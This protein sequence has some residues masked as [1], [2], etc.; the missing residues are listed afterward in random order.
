[1]DE[2][3]PHNL[4][5]T[6][7]TRAQ[8]AKIQANISKQQDM[9]RAYEARE[10]SRTINDIIEM[11]QCTEE[12]AVTALKKSKGS[13]DKAISK[14]INL[15]RKQQVAARRMEMGTSRTQRAVSEPVSLPEDAIVTVS[16]SRRSSTSSGASLGVVSQRRSGRAKEIAA[17]P[18]SSK[19]RVI[20]PKIT[21]VKKMKEVLKKATQK[22]QVSR[23]GRVTHKATK[24]CQLISIGA[25]DTRLKFSNSG[26]IFPVGFKSYITYISSED[27]ST[28]CRHT[29]EIVAPQNVGKKGSRE[30][31]N[32]RPIFRITAEDREDEPL[33]GNSATAPW[34]KILERINMGRKKRKMPE[35]HTAIAG[36]EYFGLNSPDVVQ[37]IEALPNAEKCTKYWAGKQ[38]L[39]AQRGLAEKGENYGRK[40]REKRAM[41]STPKPAKR[42]K[43]GTGSSNSRRTPSNQS[44]RR[45]SSRP[46][47]NGTRAASGRSRRSIQFVEDVLYTSEHEQYQ[48]YWSTVGRSERLRNRRKNAGESVDDLDLS[49]KTNN[50]LHG[51]IDKITLDPIENPH[52][53]PAGHVLGLQTWLMCIKRNKMCPFTKKIL[54]KSDLIKLTMDNF[55]TYKSKIVGMEL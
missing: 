28:H 38:V 2:G 9:L 29:C 23:F 37:A 36:P 19:A 20:I 39:L 30:W 16:S 27:P 40:A 31:N 1:M 14:L 13:F 50:P 52:M 11:M 25:I 47:R 10:K 54:K 17:K 35:K 49:D 6:K 55:R 48:G 41:T 8:K 45:T 42:Q 43:T 12:E 26:Y 44:A 53:S 22:K 5:E 18:A 7:L 21:S 46:A 4:F 33:E 3:V 51:K 24:K 15:K 34:K 32:A